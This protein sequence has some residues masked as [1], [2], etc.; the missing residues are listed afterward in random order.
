MSPVSPVFHTEVT[1]SICLK[2]TAEWEHQ[3]VAS[4]PLCLM[5]VGC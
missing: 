4:C 1:V 2:K 3:F 5:L